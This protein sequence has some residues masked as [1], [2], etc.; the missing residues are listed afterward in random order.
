[1]LY[2]PIWP[3][4]GAVQFR[5]IVRGDDASVAVRFWGGRVI[6]L[7]VWRSI[8]P[9]PPNCWPPPPNCWPPPPNCCPPPP[10][11]CPP[12]PNCCPPPPNCCPPP[13]NCC[14]GPDLLPVVPIPP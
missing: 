2:A 12:P 1:M 13:P 3:K 10:N 6:E 7:T 14:P 8:S 9:P 11:C 4:V 5:V